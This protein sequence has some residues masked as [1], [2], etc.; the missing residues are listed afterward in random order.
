MNKLVLGLATAGLALSA[1]ATSPDKIAPVYVSPIQYARFDCDQIRWEMERVAS[2]VTQIAGAQRKQRNQD[3][4]AV[5][6]S[7]VIFWPAIFLLATDDNQDELAHLRGQYEALNRVA[8]ERKCA[9][10]EEIAT[11]Q[12]AG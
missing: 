10:A 5:A 6:V 4:A 12:A 1:C 2:R 3:T 11:A 8:V 7:V 9:V